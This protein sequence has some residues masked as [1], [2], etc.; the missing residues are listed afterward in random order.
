MLAIQKTPLRMM[1]SQNEKT[2]C[3]IDGSGYIFRAFY[4]LPPMNRADG[5]PTNA[6]YGFTNMLMNLLSENNCAHIMVVFDAKRQNFRNAIY[7]EYKANRR[8]TPETLIPQFPLIREACNALNVPWIEMEGYEADDLIA[9]YAKLASEKGWQ[10]TVI[11]ADKDLM[12]LMTPN[13]SLYDPM[14]KKI[15]TI[16]DVQ[17]KFGVTP[18]KVTDVQ[19]LMGDSTDNIPGASGIG[20]KTAAELIQKFGSLHALLDHLNEIPQQKRREGLLR[21]K[22]KILISE[23]LVIL[24]N[25]VPVSDD[26]EQFKKRPYNDQVLFEFLTQNGFQSL[27]KKVQ[28]TPQSNIESQ[29]QTLVDYACIQT[30][31]ELTK[32]LNTITDKLVL[33]PQT[34]LKTNQLLGLALANTTNKACYIPL[35]HTGSTQDI[36]EDLFTAS[37]R[38]QQISPSQCSLLLQPILSNAHVLKIGTDIKQVWH[39]LS[40]AFRAEI[41]LTP[42]ADIE[43]MSCDLDGSKHQH[44]LEVL[45]KLHLDQDLPDYGTLLGKGKSQTNFQSLSLQEATDFAAQRAAVIGKLYT[46]LQKKLATDKSLEIYQDIDAPLISILYRMEKTGIL[47]DQNN[48][49]ELEKYYAEYLAKL[50]HTIHQTAQEEFNINSP[51]QLGTILYEK[52]GCSGGKKGSNGHWITDVKALEGLSEQGDLLAQQVLQYRSAS[53][54]KSTY[55]DALIERAHKDPRIHTTFS[56]TATNTGRLASSN[57]NLQNIPIRTEEGKAIRRVFIAQK[58]HKLISADYSQIELRLMADVANVQKLKESFLKGE[59]IHARTASQ[60]LNI[61]LD[62]IT[63]DQRR[64]AKAINFGIIYG[65]SPF[66]LAAQ[67]GISR[68]EAKTYIDTYFQQYP[69]IKKYMEETEHF[70]EQHGY[71]TTPFGRKVYI[72]GL[73]NRITKSFALRAAINAPIQGGAADIIKMAMIRI[74]HTLKQSNLNIQL[75]LQVHDELVFEVAADDVQA[76][77]EIIK[78]QM[79]QVVKLSIPLIAEVGIGDNWKDAH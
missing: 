25:N 39:I 51:A 23:K 64:R 27:A 67:L 17:N 40:T 18:D 14:K 45:A 61:P 59:D 70:V 43:L 41:N 74:H 6:V 37:N 20:P 44:T 79:E 35:A 31:Q 72:A 65:I 69:E 57:P 53:K 16:Q 52:R 66:G 13:V 15:I 63:A 1:N 42:L 9:T 7:P 62:Q 68:T 30:A 24:D 5:T 22:D 2:L 76:A 77:A 58:N 11:S 33:Y 56:L 55:V 21:D 48:L 71:V 8:E 46:I 73:D 4:A 50:T 10:I 36:K 38:P 47:V 29:P 28:T 3:L 12:Q 60:V 34:D 54:L 49:H 78:K 26:F 75:L 19:S 32:W